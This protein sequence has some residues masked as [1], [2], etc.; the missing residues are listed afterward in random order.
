MPENTRSYAPISFASAPQLR[1][2][3]LL[4]RGWRE[5]DIAPYTAMGLDKD[6]MAYFP[7]TLTPEETRAHIADL[8]ERFRKWG[9]GYWAVETPDAPFA[10]FVGLS[11]PK[12]D[13]HFTPCVEIGWR[14]AR[15]AQGKGYAV[16]AAREALR[17]GFEDMALTE[18]VAMISKENV[19]SCRVAER[20]G[21]TR[22]PADDFEYPDDD[23]G[24]AYRA[25]FLYR[26][27][28][29]ALKPPLQ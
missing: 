10:G 6:V 16:E 11:R 14:L 9:F 5:S 17:F 4:L 26:I 25:C 20:I 19:A 22:D 13:A 28:S 29:R 18:I 27:Q 24:W 23:P 3:R 7:S 8:Q 12:I 2:E 15:G 1:T 21:M